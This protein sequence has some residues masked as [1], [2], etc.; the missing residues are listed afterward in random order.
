MARIL[1]TGAAGFI[2]FHLARRLLARGDQV[3]GLD[4]LC[5]YYDVALKQARLAEL[6]PHGGFRFVRADLA[7]RAALEGVF[8]GDRFDA[9]VNLA[10]QVGVRHSVNHPR[11]FIDSNVVGFLNVLE[12]CRAGGAGHL[13]YASSSSVYGA[14]TALPFS[15]EGGGT[16]H[17]LNL[18]AASKKANELMAHAY[19]SLHALPTTGLRFFSVYGPWG[20][21]DMA[22]FLFVRAVLE[23]KPIL[24]FN[25]GQ[26][27][28]DFT[29]VDDI[30]EG[31]VRV[32]DRPPA[33]DASWSG[34]QPV[35]GAS[36]APYRVYNLGSHRP[37]PVLH[38][39]RVIESCLGRRAD[40]RMLPRQPGEALATF[41][42]VEGLARDFDFSPS[43]PVEVGMRRFVEW[44]LRFHG[45]TA[46]ASP[47]DTDAAPQVTADAA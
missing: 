12:G 27:E 33:P 25:H 24:V 45:A 28:R 7:D 21:P 11:D 34:D 26:M 37:V 38:L 14:T 23:G 29:Y 16:D 8:A 13:V 40:V 19:S 1:V 22:P 10:A 4:N 2:G 3:T 20:R 43:T 35:P 39:V 42:D 41:A 46:T 15:V 9:V 36:A 30:V 32:L 44:Y 31:I 5:D 18:Y 47:V 6:L 17:P